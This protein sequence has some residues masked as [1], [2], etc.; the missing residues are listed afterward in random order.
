MEDLY[1]GTNSQLQAGL[2]QLIFLSSKNNKLL[3]VNSSKLPKSMQ[4]L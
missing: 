1:W 3:G 2:S 4:S